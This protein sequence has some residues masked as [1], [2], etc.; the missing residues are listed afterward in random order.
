MRN[1]LVPTDFSENC[2]KAANVGIAMAKLFDAEIHFFHLIQTPVDWVKL[3][4]QLVE[5]YQL[6][7]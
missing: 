6:V 3:D 4:K 2:N 5:K 1:I 7:E